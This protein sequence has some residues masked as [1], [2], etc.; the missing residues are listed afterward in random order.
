[1]FILT[2]AT[3]QKGNNQFTIFDSTDFIEQTISDSQLMQIIKGNPKIKILGL[4][5]NGS[6]KIEVDKTVIEEL[7]SWQTGVKMFR[8]PT[9]NWGM[10]KVF[11]LKSSVS[12]EYRNILIC[13]QGVDE[14]VV[15][16][17]SVPKKDPMFRLFYTEV[18]AIQPLSYKDK[19]IYWVILGFADKNERKMY[20]KDIL[21]C[22]RVLLETE[23]ED[24]RIASGG[25][26]GFSGIDMKN[27][28]ITSDILTNGVKKVNLQR[29]L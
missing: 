11:Y 26:N 22:N 3:L 6:G 24:D 7:Q 20:N 5:H 23:W 10:F 15:R 18:Y 16:L 17:K 28:R 1:M 21:F 8:L 27:N 29:L 14:A 2:E 9:K 13:E 4:K 12:S 19:T 25:L